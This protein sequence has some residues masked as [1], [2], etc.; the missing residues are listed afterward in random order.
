MADDWITASL[1]KGWMPDLI[2]FGVPEGGLIEAKNRLPLDDRYAKAPDKQDYSIVTI[3]T[4]T[5]TGGSGLDDCTI[6]G[7]YTGTTQIVYKVEIDATGTPDT[8]EWFKDGVSQDTGVAITGA[9]QTLDNGVTVTFVATTGHTILD[10]WSSTAYPK[11]TSDTPQ[12]GVEY[13]AADGS[14]QAFVG[15]ASGLHRINSNK[16]IETLSK[17][18]GYTTGGNLWSFVQYGDQIIASNYVDDIQVKSDMT[19]TDLFAD[20]GG[21]P[22]KAKYM[23]FHKGHLILGNINTGTIFPKSLQ[24]SGLEAPTSWTPSLQTGAGT[25]T[26]PDSDEI[27]GMATAGDGFAV[28][29]RNSISYGYYSG[30]RYTFNFQHNRIKNIGCDFPGSII[31]VGSAVY[32]WGADDIYMFNGQAVTPLGF[33]VKETVLNNMQ[34][35]YDYRITA[36]HDVE[37]G[38]IYWS[39]PNATT[40]DGNATRVLCYNYRVKRFTWLDVTTEFLMGL[41]TGGITDMDAIDDI[42]ATI[43]EMPF[44]LDSRAYQAGGWVLACVDTDN[45]VNTFDSSYLVGVLETGEVKLD[46]DVL[47]IDNVRV[48]ASNFVTPPS[49]R[50]GSRMDENDSVSWTAYKTVGTS[51]YCNLRKSGRFNRVAVTLGDDKGIMGIDIHVKTRGKR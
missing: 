20:L 43:D 27:T 22:P 4:T 47:F 38:L 34:I 14:Y 24:W 32:F 29:H 39:W 21:S 18:G 10:D 8:Y 40:V 36:V 48:K 33:G 15:T 3:S 25:Q 16:Y 13:K 42:Y 51:G 7:T 23:L 37:K 5:Q 44:H 35:A 26:F 28:F 9:A 1:E 17:A 49:A 50:L 11:V 30:G 46:D 2:P 45:I 31:T 19:S 41:H 6:S 12:N